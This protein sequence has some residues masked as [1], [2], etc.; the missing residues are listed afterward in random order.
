MGESDKSRTAVYA[1]M[2]KEGPQYDGFKACMAGSLVT[3]CPFDE[4]YDYDNWWKWTHGWKLAERSGAL[5]LAPLDPQEKS[6]Y[7]SCCARKN[8]ASGNGENVQK[9]VSG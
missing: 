9:Y 6:S 7:A 3:D 5:P 4:I 1:S 2:Q 8:T